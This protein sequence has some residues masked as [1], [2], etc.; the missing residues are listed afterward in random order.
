VLTGKAKVMKWSF[1]WFKYRAVIIF[2]RQDNEDVETRRETESGKT[3]IDCDVGDETGAELFD[4]TLRVA[5]K[6]RVCIR[7]AA[8]KKERKQELLFSLIPL[9]RPYARLPKK[10][11][12]AFRVAI[13]HT[14]ET[15]TKRYF[16]IHLDEDELLILW[17]QVR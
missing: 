11:A 16:P 12:L 2:K 8:F 17:Q 10:Q 9:L 13:D 4:I 5:D 1:S 15:E 14:I 7:K 3:D 6:L